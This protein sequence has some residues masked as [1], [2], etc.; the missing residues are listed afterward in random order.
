M[1][2][3]NKNHPDF[4]WV[5]GWGGRGLLLAHPCDLRGRPTLLLYGPERP[6]DDALEALLAGIAAARPSEH[7][8]PRRVVVHPL[9]APLAVLGD[10]TSNVGTMLRH[11]QSARLVTSTAEDFPQNEVLNLASRV[12]ILDDIV[13]SGPYQSIAASG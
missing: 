12:N 2:N 8:G 13:I 5:L 7:D 6:V 10:E 4:G 3:Y 1:S 9:A 11:L